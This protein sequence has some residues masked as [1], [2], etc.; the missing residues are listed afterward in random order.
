MYLIFDTETTGLPKRWDAP[1]SDSDN[2]P[3]CIQIAWQLHDEMGKLVEHRDYLIKPDGFNIPYESEQIHGISTDLA[4]ENGTSLAEVMDSFEEV[5]SKAKFVVGHNVSFDLNVVGAEHYRLGK[6]SRLA[7]LPVLD[8]CTEVTAELLRLPGGR[9]GRYKLPTLTELHQYLFDVPFG[10]A[11]NA[12]A[13]VEAT[14]RC[15]FELIRTDVFSAS[16]LQCGPDTIAAFK[17]VNPER[18]APAGLNHINLKKASEELREK[19]EGAKTTVVTP[20]RLSNDRNSG[21]S[22]GCPFCSFA[23][24]YPVFRSAIHYCHSGPDQ[25]HCTTGPASGG[26]YRSCEYDGCVSFCQSNIQSQ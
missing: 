7:S 24:P 4:T 20:D 17:Q 15:F 10:E 9:G 3:R 23:Q 25:G 8:S 6:D 18:I 2:W 21:N 13:D 5:L 12:S 16:M 11:H 14:T 22:Q 1:V 26:H 19:K